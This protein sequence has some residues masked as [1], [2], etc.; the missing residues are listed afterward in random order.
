MTT[1]DYEGKSWEKTPPVNKTM[2]IEEMKRRVAAGI[3]RRE[4]AGEMQRSDLPTLR[5]QPS[6][7]NM[8]KKHRRVLVSAS[9]LAIY[10]LANNERE[11]YCGAADAIRA[12]CH[13]SGH[14]ASLFSE[15][16]KG[17]AEQAAELA[18]EDFQI[19]DQLARS[20]LDAY[21]KPSGK[22][23]SITKGEGNGNIEK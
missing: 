1:K 11:D 21:F 18:G 22:L 10:S 17:C 9:N 16:L 3:K 15:L 19:L 14:G 20:W 13:E 5:M 7:P 8:S 4:Q 12:V 23:I 2:P 6:G